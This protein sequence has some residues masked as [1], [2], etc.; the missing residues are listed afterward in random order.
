MTD[1]SVEDL[2][3]GTGSLASPVEDARPHR[4]FSLGL[5]AF[6]EPAG[7]PSSR[8]SGAFASRPEVPAADETA[9]LDAV[10]A[11][12]AVPDGP[13]DEP[14][15]GAGTGPARS[16]AA[17]T[18]GT[19]LRSPEEA[20]EPASGGTTGSVS[21]APEE[22]ADPASPESET[23]AQPDFPAAGQA[24][25]AVAGEAASPVAERGGKPAGRP[26][27]TPADKAS[28]AVVEAVSSAV[29]KGRIR[30]A[31]EVVEKVAALA[32]LEVTGVA[33]L[34]E[35][36]TGPGEESSR[37]VAPSRG[38]G[39]ARRRGR[40]VGAH[41]QDRTVAVD[42]AIVAEYGHVVMDVANEVKTN[43]ARTLSRML[44]MRVVEVNVNVDDVRLPGEV[45]PGQ[46]EEP[47][48]AGPD[49]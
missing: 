1:V 21:P 23:T 44:G 45:L 43:V 19:A 22:A 35:G 15:T 28:P 17:E 10:G 20:P 13:S 5:S 46:T 2:T 42:V 6:S 29:V 8:P 9:V 30:V 48:K 38:R 26:V 18:A 16:D 47:E 31:D 3:E 32:T 12:P 14:E 37:P 7:G 39:G 25:A 27:M 34:G 33:A 41:V 4:P 40:G 11:E 24:P 49:A 36:V